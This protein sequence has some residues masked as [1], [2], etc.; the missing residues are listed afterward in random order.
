VAH[1]SGVEETGAS[2]A[3]NARLKAEAAAADTGLWAIGD[4][5]GLEVAALDGFPGLHSAR[6]APTQKD[7]TEEL[8]RRLRGLPRPWRARFVS[9]IALARPGGPTTFHRGEVEGEV[10]PDWR[11]TAGFGYD[12][13]FVP[14]GAARTFGEMPAAEKHGWS[15]RA[16][17]VRALLDSG[18]L[19][20]VT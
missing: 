6:L 1:D 19:G 12:P 11:G 13:I 16:A 10:I 2:Y 15:H 5:S 4:D 18:E 3:D 17:A 7:R 14:A 9:V 8:L 20:L